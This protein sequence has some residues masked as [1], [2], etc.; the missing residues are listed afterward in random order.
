MRVARGEPTDATSARL[1]ALAE[2]TSDA[3][4][5]ATVHSLRG[6][7]A[8][9]AGE[10]AEAGQEMLL[11]SDEPNIGEVYLARAVRAALW[12]HDVVKAR[13]IA[14]R[15]DTHPSSAAA[16][17]AA[18]IAARAGIAALEGRSLDA[19]AGFRDG[20]ARDR[21]TGQDFALACAGLDYALLVGPEEPSVRATAAEA[22]AI[23]E[24][25]RARPYMERLDAAIAG[26][27]TDASS[28]EAT[29]SGALSR[30]PG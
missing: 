7:R 9:L 4:G 15:L 18:R 30:T 5:G 10:Y 17:I 27:A 3:L 13:E 25:I 19:I 22:R 24:R 26:Y 12:G 16:T 20:L 28:A 11:A 8:L 14:D 1:E 2:Q 29:K 23:F 6:D 21:A